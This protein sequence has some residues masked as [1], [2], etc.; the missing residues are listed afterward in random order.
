MT[1]DRERP[2]RFTPNACIEVTDQYRALYGERKP[3]AQIVNDADQYESEL[4]LLVWAGL[5][6]GDSTL[7]TGEKALTL[8]QA[9]ELMAYAPIRDIVETVRKAYLLAYGVPGDDVENFIATQRQLKAL[10]LQ[11][12]MLDMTASLDLL[13]QTMADMSEPLSSDSDLL[14]TS[15]GTSQPSEESNDS[16]S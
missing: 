4:R 9:G 12:Q 5:R 15:S 10:E 13:T 16:S 8:T 11:A 3:F 14:D 6:G 1:L 2:F 7:L